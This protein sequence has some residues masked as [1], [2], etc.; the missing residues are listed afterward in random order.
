[1]AKRTDPYGK[2]EWVVGNADEFICFD[3]YVDMVKNTITLHSVVNSQSGGFIED[4]QKPI[5]V[6]CEEAYGKVISMV[7]SAWLWCSENG[8]KHDTKGWNQDAQYFVRVIHAVAMM[9]AGNGYVAPARIEQPV[10][11]PP[12][13]HPAVAKKVAKKKVAKKKTTKKKVAKKKG[14][15]FELEIKKA[16]GKASEGVWCNECDCLRGECGCK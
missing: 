5:T 9:M 3:Y 6:P 10:P 14:L 4:L 13:H 2:L 12:V 7:D 16:F 1:M 15:S 11:P 8:V